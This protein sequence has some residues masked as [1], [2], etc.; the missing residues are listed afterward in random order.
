MTL[1]NNNY[2]RTR[3][4]LCYQVCGNS[5]TANTD[6]AEDMASGN[7]VDGTLLVP[8]DPDAKYM[9]YGSGAFV[10]EEACFVTYAVSS[11]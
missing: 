7:F 11:T 10:Y 3:G 2:W 8:D 1:S 4:F 9:N 5:G 6:T